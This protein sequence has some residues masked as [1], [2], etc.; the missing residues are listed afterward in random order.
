M[1]QTKKATK[2]STGEKHSTT[3]T[4]RRGV[5]SIHSGGQTLQSGTGPSGSGRGQKTCIIQA[6]Q[7][8]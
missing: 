7:T 6:L 5:E 2:M 3:W 8:E 4:A 1:S